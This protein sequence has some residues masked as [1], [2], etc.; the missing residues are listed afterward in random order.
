[1]L[2]GL[3]SLMFATDDCCI[4][5]LPDVQVRDGIPDPAVADVQL[6]PAMSRPCTVSAQMTKTSRA[7]MSRLQIG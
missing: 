3:P 6:Q 7:M 5:E 4:G 2:T 1:M